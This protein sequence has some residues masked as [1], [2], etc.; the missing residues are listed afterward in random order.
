MNRSFKIIAMGWTILVVSLLLTS[1]GESPSKG[2]KN[3]EPVDSKEKAEDHND[4]KFSGNDAE[5]DA[6]FI[7]DAYSHSLCEIESAKQAV[8]HS[9]SKS[10]KDFAANMIAAH[11]NMNADI[12]KLAAKKQI[13]IQKGL[14]D[15]Q[16][17]EIKKYQDKKGKEYNEEYL[18]KMID[19]HKDAIALYEKAAEKSSDPDI[20]NFFSSSL[21]E[22][23]NHADQAMNLKDR[24]K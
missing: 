15:K 22:L 7:V 2:Y 13:S 18:Q 6:Q 23:R 1:C 10:V 12:E 20:R 8:Q 14:T 9:G 11:V 16:L 4:T 21:S 5:K 19:K 3:Q 24:L 17:E